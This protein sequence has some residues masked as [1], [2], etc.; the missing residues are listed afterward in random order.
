[1]S[2]VTSLSAA[3]ADRENDNR[4]VSPAECLEEMAKKI[5]SGRPCTSV[6]VLSLDIGEDG[7]NYDT[8]FVA[9][10]LKGS[11]MIALMETVKHDVVRLMRG[12]E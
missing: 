5:R 9:S 12:D 10:N 6:L 3:R 1:M 7:E 4:L 11:E 2:E 8:G